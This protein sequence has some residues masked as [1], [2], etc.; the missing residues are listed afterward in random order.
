[1]VRV[2]WGILGTPHHE[3]QRERSRPE[4]R[5][6]LGWCRL[7]RGLGWKRGRHQDAV[8]ATAEERAIL[9]SLLCWIPVDQTRLVFHLPRLNNAALRSARV[10]N[11]IVTDQYTP[12][13]PRPAPFARPYASGIS[14]SQNTT[15]FSRV[16]VMVSPAPLN[17]AA[18]T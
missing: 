8:I 9:D 14:Q 11:A 18:R 12:L 5:Q 10:E 4:R 16:G 13:G 2:R 17:A 15:T 6:W 7:R 3:R 1:M